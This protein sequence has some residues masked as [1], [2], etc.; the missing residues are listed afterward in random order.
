MVTEYGMSKRLGAVNYADETENAYGMQGA[1]PS[2]HSPETA[3]AIESEIR[4]ILESCHKR[5]V[6]MLIANR[7]VLEEMSATLLE[8]EVLEGDSMNELLDKVVLSDSLEDRPTAEWIS[9]TVNS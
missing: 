5:A 8:Y 4:L 3:E 1:L 2:V 7:V 9:L 6:E